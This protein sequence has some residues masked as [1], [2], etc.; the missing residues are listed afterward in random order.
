MSFPFPPVS[1]QTAY[2]FLM[3]VAASAG[4]LY[5]IGFNNVL[6]PVAA[7]ENIP[8]GLGVAKV[9]GSDYQVRLPHQD[10]A[11]VV[12]STA[13]TAGNITTVTLNGIALTPVSYAV[14]NAATMNAIAAL[15]A[16]QPNIASAS[17]D[18][19][20]TININAIQ[21][22][23][24]SVTFVTASGSAVTWVTNYSNDNVF[25]GVD[26]YIQNHANLLGPQGSAGGQPYYQ[27]D[28]VPCLTRGRVWV[29][30]ENTVTSDSQ[31]YWRIVPTLAN[32]QVGSFRGDSDGGNAILL[33][34]GII[35]WL[36]GASAGGLAVL[37]INQP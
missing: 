7:L 26:L 34:P 3:N 4:Q 18:G 22:A 20:S 37:D 32:P 12:Q 15:I 5:D 31:V 16:A 8:I 24:I 25:Y 11:A 10:I 17:Y 33:S 29:T 1:G 2:N 27:G 28:A 35:R 36:V 30:P 14:S 19:F 23:A 13:L 21:G 9:I 6:T